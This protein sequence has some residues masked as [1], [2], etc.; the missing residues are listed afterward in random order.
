MN[1]YALEK[2]RDKPIL[3]QWG[4]PLPIYLPGPS[5]PLVPCST[6]HGP[7]GRMS[8]LSTP[9]P[10]LCPDP[11]RDKL[12]SAEGR[13]SSLT[14]L[15]GLREGVQC[16]RNGGVFH[17]WRSPKEVSVFGVCQWLVWGREEGIPGEPP[18]SESSSEVGLGTPKYPQGLHGSFGEER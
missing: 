11:M 8:I 17:P 7:S 6:S 5:H 9:S 12:P 18:G 4:K 10:S 14:G 3:T 16:W 15:P 13:L 2:P 1:S